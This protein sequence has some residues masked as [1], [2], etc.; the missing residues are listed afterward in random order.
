MPVQMSVL[1][2]NCK[3]HT[4]FVEVPE[5]VIENLN[6]MREKSGGDIASWLANQTLPFPTGDLMV[7]KGCLER[8]GIR[9]IEGP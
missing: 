4:E 9:F 3:K 6:M 2:P 5:P 8:H 7:C 1:C